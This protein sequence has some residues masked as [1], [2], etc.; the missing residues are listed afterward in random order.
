MSND[1][2]I[3]NIQSQKEINY[4]FNHHLLKTRQNICSANPNHK[5]KVSKLPKI[6]K[7]P[8]KKETELGLR[9]SIRFPAT[10][11]FY[12]RL[13]ISTAKQ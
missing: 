3:N 11:N 4:N 10:E 1:E 6:L 9:T 13:K 12:K 8:S 5:L 7:P 2:N